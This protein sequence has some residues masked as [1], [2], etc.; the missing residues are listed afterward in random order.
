MKT[1]DGKHGGRLVHFLQALKPKVSKTGKAC[2]R[3]RNFLNI[4]KTRTESIIPLKLEITQII[5]DMA[6]LMTISSEDC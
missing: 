4:L 1:P 2:I 6:W 5:K 3:F